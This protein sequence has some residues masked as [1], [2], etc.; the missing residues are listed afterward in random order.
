MP[1]RRKTPLKRSPFKRSRPKPNP[2]GHAPAHLAWIRQQPCCVCGGTFG[3][4]PH[5]STVGRGLSRKTSDRETM[6]LCV[7]HHRE[8]HGASGYFGGWGKR[9]RRRWQNQMV[10]LYAPEGQTI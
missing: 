7:K 6:P 5:H 2:A 8:F 4:V 9:D 10:A 1:L 3:V